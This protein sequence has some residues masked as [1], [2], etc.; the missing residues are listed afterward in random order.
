[1][2]Q[3]YQHS[4]ILK[5]ERCIGCT[6]CLKVCPTEAIRV[7]N[8]KAK[9]IPERCI[10]CGECIKICPNHAK[11]VTTD[12]ISII[13]K[14]KYNIVIPSLTLYGQFPSN[15]GIGKMLNAIKKIGFDEVAE[16]ALGARISVH[17]LKDHVLKKPGLKYPIIN[18]SCPAVIRL[19]QVRFPDLLP[20]IIDLETPIEIAA[21]IA[22]TEAM[23]KT[24]LPYDDIGV[25]FITPCTARVTSVKN[26]LGIDKSYIDGV[27]SIRDVYGDIVRNI[28]RVKNGSLG[29]STKESLL[30]AIAGGQAEAVNVENYLEVDGIS[31]VIKVLEEVELGKL[32][33]IEF[34][35][36]SACSGGCVGGPLLIQNSFIAKNRIMNY[37]K[38][39][40]KSEMEKEELDKYVEMYENGFLRLT[41]KIEPKSVMSLDT[42]LIKSIHK[43]EMVTEIM[44]NLPGLDCGVCGSPTCRAFAEDIVK[45]ENGDGN[46]SVCI[47]KT[48]N[49]FKDKKS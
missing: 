4:V 29:Q 20:N 43:M 32:D 11:N 13:K 5:E 48:M 1:M 7:R 31:N 21:R 44:K 19:I 17:L 46:K 3:D 28:D 15:I 49:Y 35:E 14:F 18:S 9:I 2:E 39:A 8:G 12:D 30:W 41:K 22:K 38:V 33:D 36:C 26:P 47:V 10:D 45:G 16:A 24:G 37:V 23:K 34:I 6:S 42:D 27:I 40:D 25:V